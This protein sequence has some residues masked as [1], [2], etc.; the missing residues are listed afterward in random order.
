MTKD[1]HDKLIKSIDKFALLSYTVTSE[2][3][4]IDGDDT[5]SMYHGTEWDDTITDASCMEKVN[6]MNDKSYYSKPLASDYKKLITVD[7]TL[8]QGKDELVVNHDVVDKFGRSIEKAI[9]LELDDEDSLSKQHDSP[10]KTEE[11]DFD[12]DCNQI[13]QNELKVIELEQQVTEMDS[14][15]IKLK[16]KLEDSKQRADKKEEMINKLLKENEVLLNDNTE[17]DDKVKDLELQLLQI[18]NEKERCE[19]LADSLSLQNR[20]SNKENEPL[21]LLKK[22]L[23]LK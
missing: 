19:K 14:E 3:V 4:E 21:D 15:I 20:S 12:D 5:F 8:S 22:D 23:D 18:T 1:C 7:F 16:K 10:L 9:P 13:Q 11:P 6:V 17:M 2:L